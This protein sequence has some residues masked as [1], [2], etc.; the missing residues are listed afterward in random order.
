MLK[1]LKSFIFYNLNNDNHETY[2]KYL[3]FYNNFKK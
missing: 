1:V 3:N 2:I